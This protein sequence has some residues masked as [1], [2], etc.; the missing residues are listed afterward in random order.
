MAFDAGASGWFS[1]GRIDLTGQ[2]LGDHGRLDASD[3]VG[4]LI[5]SAPRI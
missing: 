2:C 4:L 1:C 5:D 3:F